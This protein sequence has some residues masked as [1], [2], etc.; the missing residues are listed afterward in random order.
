ML[1][2]QALVTD[3]A[4]RIGV[5]PADARSAAEATVAALAR[6]IDEP[7]RRRLL[8]AV[9]AA[10]R[11]ASGDAP[12]AAPDVESFVAEV[13]WLTGTR[14]EQARYRAQAVLATLAEH[15]PGLVEALGIP[16]P[17][18]VLCADPAPGGGVT[19]PTGHT[20]PL[21][22]AEVF[23]ALAGLPYW[24]GSRRAL[25]RTMKLPAGNLDRVLARIAALHRS[26]GRG[27]EIR[28]SGETAVIT[29]RTHA[30]RAVTALDID[31]AHRIDD[32][33]DEAAAGIA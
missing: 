16:Q 15:E 29:V 19:G 7:E 4:G 31:L 13:A 21:T 1:R 5:T 8:D 28:R 22:P 11:L 24:G 18:R 26:L 17:L 10:I 2:Y 25:S 6:T 30:V 3:V 32:A 23:T 9:P 27:P 33:I 20:A 12:G 14:P